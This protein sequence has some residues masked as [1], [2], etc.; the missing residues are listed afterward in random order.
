MDL[1]EL[2]FGP[3]FWGSG[4]PFSEAFAANFINLGP[5]DTAQS[6]FHRRFTV[7][8]M[9]GCLGE[10]KLSH[11]IQ[12]RPL[13]RSHLATFSTSAFNRFRRQRTHSKLEAGA[14]AESLSDPE[15][16][17]WR[18]CVTRT[19]ST[20]SSHLLAEAGLAVPGAVRAGEWGGQEVGGQEL[21]SAAWA[22]WPPGADASTR[23]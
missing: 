1:G 20:K 23:C 18:A 3:H 19:V 4:R 22:A 8:Q 12:C 10:D 14:S 13:Q 16:P 9:M 5:F 15:E 11:S 17:I 2:F 7:A 21:W 6:T